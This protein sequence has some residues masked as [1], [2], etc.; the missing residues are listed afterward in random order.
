MN[1][2]TARC[3]GGICVHLRLSDLHLCVRHQIQ[4]PKMQINGF[5]ATLNGALDAP[6]TPDPLTC[7]V[8]P[9]PA[10]S[11][12]RSEKVPTPLAA[13]TVLVPESVPPLGF[14]P[15]AIV[16]DPLK[17]VAA[18]PKASNAVTF[19]AGEMLVAVWVLLGCT[20]KDSV[21][22]APAAILKDALVAP[23]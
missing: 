8:Y 5:C 1:A 18:L 15:M 13:V 2:D 9:L 4:M 3:F 11:I 10:R 21:L 19:T 23:V 14:C 20:V 7:S 12:W 6:E 22:A 17:P 16:I